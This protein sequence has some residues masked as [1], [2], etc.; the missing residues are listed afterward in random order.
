MKLLYSNVP[1]LKQP[2]ESYSL[3]SFVNETLP[4]ADTL[5]CA[6]GYKV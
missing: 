5:F 6:V 2:S 3:S 4:Q 1:P